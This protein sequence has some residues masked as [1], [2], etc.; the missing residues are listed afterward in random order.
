MSNKKSEFSLS[1][2]DKEVHF[3]TLSCPISS[4]PQAVIKTIKSGAT[5]PYH[6]YCP[7]C[8]SA[9]VIHYQGFIAE[10]DFDL[11]KADIKIQGLPSTPKRSSLSQ[12]SSNTQSEL[13][14]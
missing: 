9:L 7:N 13:S 3:L 14:L 5:L 10:S 4:C 2:P 12:A 1:G 8:K 6:I 11:V